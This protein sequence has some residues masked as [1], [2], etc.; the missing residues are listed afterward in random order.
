M[1]VVLVVAAT[2][3]DDFKCAAVSGVFVTGEWG[4]PDFPLALTLT[5]PLA[6]RL[7]VPNPPTHKALGA[8]LLS[9]DNPEEEMAT[10][11]E[12]GL[13]SV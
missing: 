6:F 2:T 1:V 4:P 12:A 10:V 5:V 9:P 3:D 8:D 7:N 11:A 13:L